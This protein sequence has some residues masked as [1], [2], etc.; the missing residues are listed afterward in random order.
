[1]PLLAPENPELREAPINSS[2]SWIEYIVLLIP[3]NPKKHFGILSFR[4]SARLVVGI[5]T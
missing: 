1:M 3:K 5:A 2:M 4:D